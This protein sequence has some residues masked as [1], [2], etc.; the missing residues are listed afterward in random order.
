M[1]QF[2][3][4]LR[5]HKE[6]LLDPQGREIRSLDDIPQIA[7]DEARGIMSQDILAGKLDLR[8]RLEVE[9]KLG[10]IVHSLRFSDAIKIIDGGLN[11]RIGR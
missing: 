10:K 5:D 9:D 11:I 3:F 6:R 1:S 2:Y 7:L 8:Q 4:H